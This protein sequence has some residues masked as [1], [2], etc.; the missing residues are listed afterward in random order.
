MTCTDEGVEGYPSIKL[1]KDGN[2]IEDYFYARTAERMKRFLYEKLVD[3]SELEPNTIGLYTLNDF[4]FTKFIEGSGS[5][6]VLVKFYVPWCQH[7]KDLQEV[8]D[9]LGE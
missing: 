8:Y 5:T 3:I 4:T 9:E 6:P 2:I 1:Y 7:C